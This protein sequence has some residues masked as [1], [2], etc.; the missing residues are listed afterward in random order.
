MSMCQ[1]VNDMTSPGIIKDYWEAWTPNGINCHLKWPPGLTDYIHW[2][3][4]TLNRGYYYCGGLQVNQ[5]WRMRSG[6]TCR[7]PHQWGTLKL[8]KYFPPSVYQYSTIEPQGWVSGVI[9]CKV[10]A[11]LVQVLGVLPYIE[12]WNWPHPTLLSFTLLLPTL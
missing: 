10:K 6:T 1:T 9:V 11:L 2:G 7:G 12:S 3:N 5:G 8:D 4:S